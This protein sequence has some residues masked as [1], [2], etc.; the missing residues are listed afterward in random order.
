MP[1]TAEKT[2][3]RTSCQIEKKCRDT[4]SGAHTASEVQQ[5]S[6]PSAD[7]VSAAKYAE[8]LQ[9][10]AREALPCSERSDA[11]QSG[12]LNVRSVRLTE[13]AYRVYPVLKC[14]LA[15]DREFRLVPVVPNGHQLAD[16]FFIAVKGQQR[17]DV[18]LQRFFLRF[19]RALEGLNHIFSGEQLRAI[20]TPTLVLAGSKDLVVEA[21]TRF[22]AEHIPH[23][24][25]QILQGEG[26]AS[27]IVHQTKVAEL[28]LIYCGNH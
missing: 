28:I 21:D 14:A 4:L 2:G 1:Q 15:W 17:P 12:H 6:A 16:G 18:H 13:R 19:D 27:Y 23:A 7:I 26:H 8:M 22:I 10:S 9:G 3:P 24:T 25:L 20:T 11:K 5:G